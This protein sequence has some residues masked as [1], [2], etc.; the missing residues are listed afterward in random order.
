MQ[1]R[2][3]EHIVGLIVQP[4][5]EQIGEVI[6]AHRGEDRRGATGPGC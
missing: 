4:Q 6:K 3:V 1:Q 5:V 2:A